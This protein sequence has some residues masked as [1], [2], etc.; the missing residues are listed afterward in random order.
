MQLKPLSQQTLVI[1]GA[2]SGIGLATA[3]GAAKQG[4]NLVLVARSPESLM[5]AAI[6]QRNRGGLCSHTWLSVQFA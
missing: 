1:T 5:D 4:A 3:L 6:C 2:S